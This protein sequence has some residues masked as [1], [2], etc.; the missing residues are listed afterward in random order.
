MSVPLVR[1]QYGAILGIDWRRVPGAALGPVP[2]RIDVRDVMPGDRVRLGGQ[3]VVVLKVVGSRSAKALHV[4][5][6]TDGGAEIVHEAV[7]GEQIDVVEVG[8]FG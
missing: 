5:T 7:I 4:I 8:V 3:L 1:N 6:R 2:G